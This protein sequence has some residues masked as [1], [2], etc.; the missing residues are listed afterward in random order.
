M[1]TKTKQ[2]LVITVALLAVILSCVYFQPT[3]NL[4][5]NANSDLLQILRGDRNVSDDVLLVY[6]DTQEVTELGGWPITRD[7]YGYLI[8]ALKQAGAKVIALDVLFPTENNRYP[9][10]DQDLSH[11]AKTAGN[12]CTPFEFRHLSDHI[13]IDGAT[14]LLGDKI[15]HPFKAFRAHLLGTGFSNL[16][17]ETLARFGLLTAVWQD[18]IVP[19]FGL[20]CARQFLLGDSSRI[21]LKK[22]KIILENDSTSI[23]IPIDDKQR[24]RLNHI[25]R[26]NRIP[27]MSLVDLFQTFQQNPDSLNLKGKLVFV[28]VTAPGAAPMKVT[29]LHSA[30]PATLLQLIIAENII[31]RRF[32]RMPG[33][34]LTLLITGAFAVIT[35]FIVGA[36]RRKVVIFCGLC[37]SYITLAVLLFKLASFILPIVQP[38]IASLI[39]AAGVFVLKYL[40][41]K[42]SHTT[43]QNK[44]TGDIS[45]KEQ[46]LKFERAHVA[47]LKEQLTSEQQRSIKNA[48][49]TREEL[50]K[51]EGD[52][53]KLEN[54]LL[55]M[56]ENTKQPPQKHQHIY[57]NVIHAA[58]SPM[59]T[60]L[61]LVQK[62]A[63]ADIPVLIS[64]ETGTGKE[65][66]SRAIHTSGGRKDKPFIAVNCG[67]LS[68]TLLESELFGHE[69][70]AFTG[71]TARRLG[72]FELADKGT[73]F[74][75]EITETSANFQAK[76]LR[77]LQE[78]TFERL[79]GEKTI[80]VNV[81][82][83]AA[84]SKSIIDHVN[85]NQ[86]REDLYYRLNG[87]AI[88]LPP[89]RDRDDDIPL[90]AK[91]F[92]IQYDYEK[93][94]ISK[95]A[96]EHMQKYH[97]PGNVRELENAV[98]RAA[99]LS[100]SEGRDLIREV[101]L[102]ETIKTDTKSTVSFLTFEEQVLESLR[103]FNFS[104]SSISQTAK[105]LG[106]KD[107]GTITDYLRGICFE[108]LVYADFDKHRAAIN[109][110][111]TDNIGIVARVEAKIENYLSSVKLS[112]RAAALKGLPKR[113]H[114][115][116]DKV[117]EN[118]Q[119]DNSQREL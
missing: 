10:F 92:L 53:K 13:S 41:R 71:A 35:I 1:K 40:S 96:M 85:E 75:D 59:S 6:I 32:I 117:I 42:V 17:E 99:I 87:F 31:E 100:Q 110:A 8:Y 11:F 52:I 16:S 20:E 70:G 62:V 82:I 45:Q 51:K 12:V 24:I 115:F 43:L 23:R 118:L 48:Q 90:L 3:A 56:S 2:R 97:W 63:P 76:L 111:G 119:H 108:Q 64:G 88:E 33:I 69:K 44:Y 55:D 74:L 27:S 4:V 34:L 21:H 68:E 79:G 18:S 66:I 84:S 86:F 73:L 25:K 72:R 26:L 7:Y 80:N 61:Q 22:N 101:D 95:A 39:G 105:A 112:S 47:Q 28:G 46:Q 106:N 29:P 94:A 49:A 102:P 109:V 60:V 30:F 67:A 113:F 5:A 93:T 19:S 65:I 15:Q 38:L 58:G 37:I 83:I 50:E 104:H 103:T 116:L 89:L 57:L 36:D 9:E 14:F 107:R 78:G 54:E 98:R 81:R 91:H 114:E 77:V